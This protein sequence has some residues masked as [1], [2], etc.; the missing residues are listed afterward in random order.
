V[1]QFAKLKLYGA[2]KMARITSERAIRAVGS[3]FDTVL[4]ASRRARELKQGWTPKVDSPYG[5]LVTALTEIEQGKIGREY[6][7]K[8]ANIGRHEQPE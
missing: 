7:A 4:I 1:Q 2:K 5:P 8:P 3:Q 6:L